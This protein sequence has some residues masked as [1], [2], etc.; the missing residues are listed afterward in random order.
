VFDGFLKFPSITS[1][2]PDIVPFNTSSSAQIFAF[3]NTSPFITTRHAYTDTSQEIITHF[4][5]FTSPANT[6]K[7]HSI[8][9]SILTFHPAIR[10]SSPT[11]A[12]MR[13]SPPAML[14]SCEISPL[15]SNS[16]HAIVR[17][18]LIGASMLILPPAIYRSSF[19][20]SIIS[21]SSPIFDSKA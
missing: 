3:H 11:L 5:I 1:V 2:F 12:V 14:A 13:I 20:V 16:P 17:S 4:A 10:K 21:R 19:T 8:S 6:T 9:D 15:I 18:P 7:S